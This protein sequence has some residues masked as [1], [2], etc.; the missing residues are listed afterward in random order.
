MIN[1]KNSR[2]LLVLSSLL[3]TD[4]RSSS[5]PCPRS[6]PRSRP[7]NDGVIDDDDDCCCCSDCTVQ[8]LVAHASRRLVA[9]DFVADRTMTLE[10][11]VNRSITI[12]LLGCFRIQNVF[13]LCLLMCWASS[14]SVCLC[15]R[16]FQIQFRVSRFGRCCKKLVSIMR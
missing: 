12:L 9:K 4:W 7:R 15:I 11:K 1:T 3:L 2:D 13:V 5:S 16:E 8:I 6:R 14:R 10:M